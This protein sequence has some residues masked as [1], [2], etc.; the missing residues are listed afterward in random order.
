MCRFEGKELIFN[1]KVMKWHD[2]EF[3]TDF[4]DLWLN[5]QFECRYSS[6]EELAKRLELVIIGG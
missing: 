6:S 2:N 5:G 1:V 4:F 3:N